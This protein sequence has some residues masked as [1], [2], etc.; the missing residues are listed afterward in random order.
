MKKIK[1]NSLI[2]AAVVGCGGIAQ[3]MHLPLLIKHPDVQVKAICDVD[4]SKAAIIAD[5]FQVPRIYVDIAD[6]LTHEDI[7]I[8]F[9]L[10]PNN[11][12][13]PMSLISLE[14]GAH[15][16]IEKP[17]AR[18]REEVL[19]IKDKAKEVGREVMVGM[20][21]RFRKDVIALRRFIE[22]EE[23]GEIFFAK[24]AWLHAQHQSVKQSWLFQK[25]VSGGGV[26]MDLGVQ[27][28]DLAWWLLRKPVPK[29]VKSFSYQI[30]PTLSVEDFC[31][32]CITF[33]NNLSLSLEISWDFPIPEDH[34]F[35]EIVGQK[36][37]G[38]LNPVKIQKMML[39]Q[40][41]NITP[42]I[43]ES[44]I[45]NFKMGYQNEINHF[46]D[47]LTGREDHLESTIDDALV[48][49]RMIDGIYES[50]KLKQEVRLS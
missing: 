15:L 25:N 1:K 16:F 18:N 35:L 27:M 10:T 4:N 9:I 22:G 3:V 36:G 29:V 2:N 31:V 20:Q 46:I 44:K 13:L 17:A 42:E 8:V 38:N 49:F 41:M 45:S 50:I 24:A 28:I 5:K 40:I 47:Y 34:F 48:V 14:H 6:L 12:H 33:E 11:L 19:R 7:D 21:N 43:K 30:N 26:V 39:G 23:L 32:S 37:I